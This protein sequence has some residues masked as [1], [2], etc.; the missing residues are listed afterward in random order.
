MPFAPINLSYDL[1]NKLENFVKNHNFIEL[2]KEYRWHRDTWQNGF[3]DILKLEK[4]ITNIA[5]NNFLRKEDILSVATWGSKKKF[6][7][8][9][10]ESPKILPLSLYDK[11]GYPDKRIEKDPLIPLKELQAN[12]K[13]LG[14]T[15]L[16]KILRFAL[17]SEFGAIDTRIV[18][19]VGEG[20]PN[21]KRQEW[22]SLK[23][24]KDGQCIPKNQ[25]AWPSEYFTWINILRFFAHFLNKSGKFC[26]HP[27]DFLKEGLRTPGVWT[28]ADVEMALFSYASKNIK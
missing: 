3:P 1:Q 19:V 7:L 11:N 6:N 5:R 2:Y 24:R 13:G 15:Y 22:L 20:D 9:K 21:S 25:S 23:V 27:K 8:Q 4:E 17:P 16:S 18:R 28:C 14:P 10:I 26:P 12:T